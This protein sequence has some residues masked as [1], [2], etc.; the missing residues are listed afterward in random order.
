[1]REDVEIDDRVVVTRDDPIVVEVPVAV[2]AH[3]GG[4]DAEVD[5]AVV[6]AGNRAVKV[7]VS[8]VRVHDNCV[9]ARD[10]LPAPA[11]GLADGDAQNLF[12]R[13]PRERRKPG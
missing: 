9:A 5:R 13:R 4:Q 2:T 1:L 11:A 12:R 7:H 6:V 10:G 8:P 3:A